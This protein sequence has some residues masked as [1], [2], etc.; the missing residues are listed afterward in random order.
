MLEHILARPR[1]AEIAFVL[2][3]APPPPGMGRVSQAP[4]RENNETFGPTQQ[5]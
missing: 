2:L 3:L 1:S 4:Q 5:N